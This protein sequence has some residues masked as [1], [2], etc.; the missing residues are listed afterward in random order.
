MRER[1]A[2]SV[3]AARHSPL[4][5]V[6]NDHARTSLEENEDLRHILSLLATA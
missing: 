1:K 5:P 2:V 4:E 3:H 6:N